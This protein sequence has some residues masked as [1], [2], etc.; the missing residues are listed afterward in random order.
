MYN[1]KTT[2]HDVWQELIGMFESQDVITEMFLRDYLQ[3]LKMKEGESVIKHIQS[4]WSLLEQLSTA[5]ALVINEDAILP[6]MRFMPLSYKAFITSM[7]RHL[8]IA[9]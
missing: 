3:T 1:K 9:L 4:F 7:W 5:K 8:N 6:L 2:S